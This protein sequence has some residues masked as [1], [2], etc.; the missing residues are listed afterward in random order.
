MAV[1]V[2]REARHSS[3]PLST[4]VATAAQVA[5]V[6]NGFEWIL[7]HFYHQRGTLN[8]VVLNLTESYVIT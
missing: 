4:W 7:M 5:G 8:M 1:R 6:L 3:M 2:A